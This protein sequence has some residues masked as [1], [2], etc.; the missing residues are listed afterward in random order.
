MR[1]INKHAKLTAMSSNEGPLIKRIKHS[2]LFLDIDNQCLPYSGASERI[3]YCILIK[4]SITYEL[5]TYL[6]LELIS[7]INPFY[8]N[9]IILMV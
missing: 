6:E 4:M 2:V 8:T 3:L 5:N 7:L 9:G 1:F